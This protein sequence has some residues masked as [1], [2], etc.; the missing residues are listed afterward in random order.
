MSY[1]VSITNT[2]VVVA[3]ENEQAATQFARNYCGDY[4]TDFRNK[5]RVELESSEPF[6]RETFYTF[7]LSTVR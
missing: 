1:L 3:A 5:N 4:R 2:Q 7:A 6:G